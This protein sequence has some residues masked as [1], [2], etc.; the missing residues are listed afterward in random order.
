[1]LGN[2]ITESD[3]I[4][5]FWFG[6]D[7]CMD[8]GLLLSGYVDH[9]PV[10]RYC[11]QTTHVDERYP[12]YFQNRG[13]F[14]M[15]WCL[16]NPKSVVYSLMYN[17]SDWGLNVT[18][19]RCGLA[20]VQM[21]RVQRLAH[22][23]FGTR[24]V[25]RLERACMIYNSKVSQLFI[26][27]R[28]LPPERLLVIDYDE[29]VKRKNEM[30]PKVYEFIELEYKQQYADKILGTSIDK[31]SKLSKREASFIQTECGPVYQEAREHRSFQ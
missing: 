28:N 7:P 14:R 13:D 19:R 1:M 9:D 31:A 27:A 18:F 5:N 16:R 30:L 2:V 24:V 10:G 23:V 20:D 8:A 26:L 17:W 25:S 22:K 11:F 4:N 29:L 12:E 15:I 3:G 6:V 21:G